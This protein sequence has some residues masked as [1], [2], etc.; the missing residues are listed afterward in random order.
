M[1]LPEPTTE[2]IEELTLKI[3]RRLTAVVERLCADAFETDAL[4][5]K[6][7][8][9]LQQALAA[10]IKAPVSAQPSRS[11]SAT[12]DE[13]LVRPRRRVLAPRRT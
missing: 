1:P 2:Q 13:A 5:E 12:T 7:A 8:A 11:G 4:L 3:A 9:S 6:T 10:A